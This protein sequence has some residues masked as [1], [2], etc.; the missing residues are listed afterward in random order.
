MLQKT[1]ALWSTPQPPGAA[2]RRAL[3]RLGSLGFRVYRVEG[4]RFLAQVS[5][6]RVKGVSA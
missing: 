3:A 2:P 1:C 5:V 4:S 6:F